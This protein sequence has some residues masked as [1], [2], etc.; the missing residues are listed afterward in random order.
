MIRSTALR[1]EGSAGLS[2]VDSYGWRR[3][4]TSFKRAST[5]LCNSVA[6][7]ARRISTTLV[8]PQGLAPLLA[9]RLIA[10]DKNPGI[11][12]IGVGETVRRIMSKAILRITGPWIG[13]VAET[14]QLCAGQ[15]S[16]CEAA[17]HAM[18]KIFDENDTEAILLVDAFNSLNRKSTLLN[19][20]SLCPP[21][22]TA[23]INTHRE[24][25][26]LFIDGEIL[27]SQEGTTQGDPLAMAMYAL[28][29]LPL[30]SKLHQLAKQVWYADDA[31]AGG[32]LLQLR[33]WWDTLV[34][35]G[36]AYGY[37]ANARKTW[38]IMKPQHHAA[39]AEIFHGSCVNITAEQRVKDTL[40]QQ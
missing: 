37:F 11:R 17:V 28:G 6:M 3:F 5:E 2:G 35:I 38:L 25:A 7:V 13:E 9:C 26:E 8:D 21:I 30:I 22:A 24:N 15:E 14:V 10:L 19:I 33:E 12:P 36:P 18:K 31:M 27:F 4:C 1:I 39:A 29:T 34:S 20:H 32:K 40:V 23:L 16:G